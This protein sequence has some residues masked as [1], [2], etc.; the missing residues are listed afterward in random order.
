MNTVHFSS[1]M[2]FF[3]F[4]YVPNMNDDLEEDFIF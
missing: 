1:C 3:A 2:K 4:N